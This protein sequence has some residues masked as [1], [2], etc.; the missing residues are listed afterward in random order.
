MSVNYR[1]TLKTTRMQ[2]VRDDIDSGAGAATL[3]I[4]TAAFA[5]ILITFTLSDPAST[6]ATDTLTR[7]FGVKGRAASA[8][9]R[10]GITLVDHVPPLK[11]RFMAEARGEIAYGASFIEWFAEEG[12][13]VY[14]ETIPAPTADRRLIVLRQPV[15]VIAAITPWNFPVA[16]ITR[17][18]APALAVGCTAVVKPAEATPLCALALAALAQEAGIPAGVLNIITTARPAAVGDELTRNPT[19]RKLSFTGS[20]GVGKTHG[21]QIIIGTGT[22]RLRGRSAEQSGKQVFD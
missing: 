19:V 4:A 8:V 11:A 6:V 12:K 17:K 7:L 3:E 18:V 1:T 10:A 20:T 16:M 14:G 22:G 9:R 13:R 2:A 21:L 15:G 5:S